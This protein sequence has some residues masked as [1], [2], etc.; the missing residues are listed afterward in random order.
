MSPLLLEAIA[1]AAREGRPLAQ[2]LEASPLPGARVVAERLA[3]GQS[4]LEALAGLVPPD[5]ARLLQ[6]GT[7]PLAVLASVAAAEAW[8]RAERRRVLSHHLAQPLATL[9]ILLGLT[10]ALVVLLPPQGPYQSV[11]SPGWMAIPACLAVLIAT[12]PWHRWGPGA[13]W[14]TSWTR[15]ERWA[16]AGLAVRWRL[17]EAQAQDLLGE[18]LAGFAG[19][20]NSSGA[21][22][23][24]HLM[25]QWHQQAAERRLAWTARALAAL[26]L[27]TGGALVLAN[28]RIW[29]P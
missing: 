13:A 16:R 14:W 23:H 4:L 21:E 9:G 11:V 12:G 8:R 27:A 2:T 29:H 10:V 19:V 22:A 24:C 20:L 15:A 28:L 26:I 7:P 18:D 6:G 17:T 5:L 25:A 1:E 3:H